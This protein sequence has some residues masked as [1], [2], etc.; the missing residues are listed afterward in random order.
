M[1]QTCDGHEKGTEDC[2]KPGLVQKGKSAA[3]GFIWVAGL[4]LAGSDS[5]FMPWIN[6]LGVLMFAGIIPV[7]GSWRSCPEPS[8]ASRR[9]H[10]TTARL[11]ADP[12]VDPAPPARGVKIPCVS[13]R[14]VSFS[15]D[16]PGRIFS[17][18]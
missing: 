3:V 16:G 6:L 7:L 8:D 11:S 4:L 15:M 13:Q 5:P 14:D 18:V 1:E 17:K 10:R 12:D 2:R 9:P